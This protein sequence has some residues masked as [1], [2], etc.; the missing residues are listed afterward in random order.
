VAERDNYPVMWQG[1]IS[2]AKPAEL[3]LAPGYY[4]VAPTTPKDWGPKFSNW[5]VVWGDPADANGSTWEAFKDFWNGE[6]ITQIHRF[7]SVKGY[8]RRD[9]TRIMHVDK[10]EGFNYRPFYYWKFQDWENVPP[11]WDEKIAQW[12]EE[13]AEALW[14]TF[15][16]IFT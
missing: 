6:K 10:S 7:R 8:R 3:Q 15:K 5:W 9:W 11:S 1:T 4:I 16:N 2:S 14:T 12:A 13:K